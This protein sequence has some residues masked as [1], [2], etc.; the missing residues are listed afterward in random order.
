M[1]SALFSAENLEKES[2]QPGMRL[3]NSKML[4]IELNGECMARTGSMVAYQGQIQFQA[5]GSGGLGKFLKQK[6]TGEGVPLMKLSGRGD[7]FLADMAADVHIVDLEPGDALSINGSSVLAFDSSLQYDIK[8]VQGMGMMSSAGMFNCVFTG[9]GRIAVT[10][11]GTPV[12]LNVDQPTY[13]DPQA[14]VCWSA[15][16]QT[17]YHRAEQLGIGTLLGRRTGEAFT[18]SFAGHGFVI[19]QPSEEPPVMGA[20]TQ[21]QQQG[22]VLGNLLGG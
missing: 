7:V 21:Q 15:S 1:R 14:A 17:G 2:N 22:G 13:V 9:H 11:K 18:M 10:T 19:V 3:Q 5:L 6:L 16:L 8:M 20:G 12:V 4:K